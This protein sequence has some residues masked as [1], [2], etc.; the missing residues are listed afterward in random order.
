MQSAISSKNDSDE[1]LFFE[2]VANA[3]KELLT[4]K[5]SL[6][7]QDLHTLNTNQFSNNIQIPADIVAA[8]KTIQDQCT[9]VIYGGQLNAKDDEVLTLALDFIEML[10]R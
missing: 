6:S 8:Y 3:T 5:Y 10:E 1:K 4:I 7:P 2:S 9:K